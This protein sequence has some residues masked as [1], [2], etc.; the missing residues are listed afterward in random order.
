MIAFK[1]WERVTEWLKENRQY[2]QIRYFHEFWE[3]NWAADHIKYVKKAAD[4]GYDILEFQAQP[5]LEMNESRMS[6]IKK[7][8]DDVG[9]ELTYSLGLDK[10]YDITSADESTRRGGIE[11][12]KAIVERVAF[13]KGEII[14]GVSYEGWGSPNHIIDD[15]S[16]MLDRSVTA[17]Q[18]IVKTAAD[19]GVTYCVESV[20]RF[21][22]TI[23]N[24]AVE[25]VEYVKMVGSDNV[26]VLL[27]T[28]HMNI[29]ESS[30]G[31]AIRYAGDYLK[32]FHTGE[33]NRLPPGR[34]H[35]DW[36]EIFKAF[37]DINYTGR[38]VC[39]PFV[40]MG[41]EVGRDIKVWRNLLEDTSEAN[42][43]KEAKGLLEFQKKMAEKYA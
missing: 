37:S 38:I 32:S 40:Q 36:D 26:G 5:L 9:I 24:T 35:L 20:N 4:L 14:S 11:Y 12:L 39:E 1:W 30:M 27:D 23:I 21:E 42:L 33:N 17:M 41:G 10:K 8:A 7:P 2:E 3:K 29:E 25:A 13:M 6:E 16:K 18:E 34:G 28:Y 22:A 43:D 19:Y 15:K 31:D